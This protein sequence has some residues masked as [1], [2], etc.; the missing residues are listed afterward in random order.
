MARLESETGADDTERME[1]RALARRV[2]HFLQHPRQSVATMQQLEELASAPSDDHWHPGSPYA[3]VRHCH[4][5]NTPAEM[6]DALSHDY[7]FLEGDV[8]LEGAVRRLPLLDR[9]RE[10]IMAHDPQD[11]EGL[12]LDEWLEVGKAS[13]RGLKLDI[14]QAA[15]LPKILEEVEAHQVPDEFLI[16]NADV[17]PGPGGPS[18]WLL[19]LASVFSDKTMSGKDLKQI[20][21]QHP[22]AMLSL[23]CYTG[24]QPPGTVYSS[25]HL[26]RLERIADDVGGPVSFPLRAEFVTPEVVAELKPHGIVSIWNDP[27]SYSPADVQHETERFRAMGVDGIIDLRQQE[28]H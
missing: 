19:K 4:F 18:P 22:Q 26:E 10:P 24:A 13:G 6:R 7:N 27:T 8:H 14:K 12:S 28:A 3:D 2:C 1:L 5:T 11:S 21:E 23:G 17:V 25:A 9:F 20:R 16:F 15:A